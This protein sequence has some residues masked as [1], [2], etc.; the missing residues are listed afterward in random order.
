[1]DKERV[2][3]YFDRKDDVFKTYVNDV[4]RNGFSWVELNWRF[5][6]KVYFLKLIKMFFKVQIPSPLKRY[7]INLYL[8]QLYLV[9]IVEWYRGIIK[10]YN[11]KVVHQHQECW[12]TPLCLALAVKKEHGIF[13][14]NHWSVDHFQ[15]PISMQGLRI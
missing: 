11:I 7:D 5:K 3:L 14:W 9:F 1:M 13:V 15:F 8:V 12:P 4:E 6:S 10:K 2:V